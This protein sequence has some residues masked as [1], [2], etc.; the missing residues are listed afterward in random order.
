MF[1][2]QENDSSLKSF[3]TFCQIMQNRYCLGGF[4]QNLIFK[5]LNQ[6]SKYMVISH[7]YFTIL[8]VKV[9]SNRLLLLFL[10]SPYVVHCKQAAVM[11]FHSHLL[12]VLAPTFYPLQFSQKV[13]FPFM[14]RKLSP[15][16]PK[17]NSELIIFLIG[18]DIAK[19]F[20]IFSRPQHTTC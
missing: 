13:W 18:K 8:H 15:L 6:R 3:P 5:I 1:K 19:F 7:F 2:S 10:T 20:I 11:V 9:I 14:Y 4:E 17:N 12:L 16:L